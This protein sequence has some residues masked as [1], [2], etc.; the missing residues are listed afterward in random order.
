MMN[1]SNFFDYLKKINVKAALFLFLLLTSLYLFGD[2]VKDV[3][4]EKEGNV[5]EAA[6]A[7]LDSYINPHLTKAMVII[8]LFGSG[9]FLL[10]AYVLLVIWLLVKKKK[11]IAFN[12]AIIGITSS[13]LVFILKRLF[14][15]TRPTN[16]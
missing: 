11:P 5:D 4:W 7:F 8:S 15:R 13:V 16:H 12:A 3:L 2:L 6:F 9:Y 1:Y 14:H 10:P